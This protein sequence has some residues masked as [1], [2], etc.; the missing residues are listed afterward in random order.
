MLI[1]FVISRFKEELVDA[2]YDV[3]I[4]SHG[5]DAINILLL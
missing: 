4:A 2:G 3:E 5:I 1:L